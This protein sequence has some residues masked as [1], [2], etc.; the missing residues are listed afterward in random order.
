MA[1]LLKHGIE[2]YKELSTGFILAT[3]NLT[4]CHKIRTDY[5][6]MALTE[7]ELPIK[8]DEYWFGDYTEGRYA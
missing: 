3:A 5:G 4:D 7:S 2:C 1:A 8:G 6:I